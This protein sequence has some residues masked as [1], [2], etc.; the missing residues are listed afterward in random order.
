M[1][2]RFSVKV[3]TRE[4][5]VELDTGNDQGA[6]NGRPRIS[7]DGLARDLDVRQV[8]PGVWS[9]MD[10]VRQSIAHIVG[11]APKLINY[12]PHFG[13]L[14]NQ[15]NVAGVSTFPQLGQL[16]VPNIRPIPYFLHV[17]YVGAGAKQLRFASDERER[18]QLCAARALNRADGVRLHGVRL[19]LDVERLQCLGGEQRP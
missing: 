13:L 2:R 16:H 15:R 18:R 3:G 8:E 4:R 6:G 9:L 11:A 7:V 14:S 5:I 10:G 12:F 17:C 19:A 1:L